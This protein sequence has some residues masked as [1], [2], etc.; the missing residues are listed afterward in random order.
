MP[1][2]RIAK[3]R[4]KQEDTIKGRN[5]TFN[6]FLSI[7]AYTKKSDIEYFRVPGSKIC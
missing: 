5:K 4:E 1:K 6:F 7:K 2:F 3:E